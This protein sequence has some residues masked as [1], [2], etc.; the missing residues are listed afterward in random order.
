MSSNNPRTTQAHVIEKFSGQYFGIWAIQ[1]QVS[2]SKERLWPLDNLTKERRLEALAYLYSA[3][4]R[5]IVAALGTPT[6]PHQLWS[7]L[8]QKYGPDRSETHLVSIESSLYKTSLENPIDLPTFIA[9]FRSKVHELRACGGSMSDTKAGLI[10]LQNLPNHFQAF[11]Q[12]YQASRPGAWDLDD[13]CTQLQRLPLPRSN[14]LSF[15]S[16]STTQP[17]KSN[18]SKSLYSLSSVQIPKPTN[19][20]PPSQCP[21]CTEWH[22]KSECPERFQWKC[23]TCS[24][25]GH[26]SSNCRARNLLQPQANSTFVSK[27]HYALSAISIPQ[28]P[29]GEV[30]PQSEELKN[31]AKR[32]KSRTK[33]R[34]ISETDL[35]Q[36]TNMLTN[37]RKSLNAPTTIPPDR[38]SVGLSAR[39]E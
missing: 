34:N 23:T 16:I 18:D 11:A 6:D 13:L 29:G 10:L 7:A 35:N 33:L 36:N 4:D 17:R 30:S 15:A 37:P 21:F 19:I 25:F 14:I 28:E 39:I 2:L 31:G 24:K 5:C 22:W 1:I 3:I 20:L 12:G 32:T 9:E 8:L 26:I 38:R 27:P